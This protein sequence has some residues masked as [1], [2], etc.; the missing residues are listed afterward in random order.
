[1]PNFSAL[2]IKIRYSYLFSSTIVG[3]ARVTFDNEMLLKEIPIFKSDDKLMT[4]MSIEPIAMCCEGVDIKILN[5]MIWSLR[6]VM[7][8]AIIEEYKSFNSNIHKNEE[9]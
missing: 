4:Q 5:K 2:T 1:M 3:F 6:D 9:L 7:E 8:M